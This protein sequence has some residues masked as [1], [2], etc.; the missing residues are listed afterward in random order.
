[1][2]VS[3]D[4]EEVNE[5]NEIFCFACVAR[6]GPGIG[7]ELGRFKPALRKSGLRGEYFP[8]LAEK[9]RENVNPIPNLTDVS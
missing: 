7:Q 8:L 1:M 5:E 2:R 9:W 4:N 3:A 6:S